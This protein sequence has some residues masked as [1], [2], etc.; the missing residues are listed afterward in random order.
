[1]RHRC[2]ERSICF[3]SVTFTIETL[4]C[5]IHVVNNQWGPEPYVWNGVN[6]ISCRNRSVLSKLG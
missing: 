5:L 4:D 1:M 2:I 6:P 3:E